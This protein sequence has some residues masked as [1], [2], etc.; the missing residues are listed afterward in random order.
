MNAM[1]LYWFT[2]V[3]GNGMVLPGIKPFPESMLIQISAPSGL[4]IKYLVYMPIGHMVLK[5]YVPCKNFDVPSQYLYKPCQ[6]YVYCWKNMYM[7]I[8][9]KITCPLR[10]VTTK[11][12]VPWDKIY[13]PRARGHALMSSPDCMSSE[14]HNE[15]IFEW[16]EKFMG[17][18]RPFSF[19]SSGEQKWFAI[20]DGFH[21]KHNVALQSALSLLMAGART[22]AGRMMTNFGSCI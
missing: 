7:P 10:H 2:I 14:G 20:T 15:L 5:I 6:A 16:H 11:V 1:E 9:K 18:H 13:M 4:D 19:T 17:S 3:S 21:R 12:Y 8:L 22:S